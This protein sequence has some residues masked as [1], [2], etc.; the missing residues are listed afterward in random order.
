MTNPHDIIIKP[1]I[2]ENSMDDMASKKY[3]FTVNKKANKIQSFSGNFED[4][5]LLKRKK[6]IV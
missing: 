3:T 2:T 1:I 4:K 5:K 6:I